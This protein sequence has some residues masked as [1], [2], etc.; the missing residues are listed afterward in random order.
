MI[1][2]SCYLR[3]RELTG[4]LASQLVAPQP[5]G[6]KHFMFWA[7]VLHPSELLQRSKT[8]RWDESL[9][10]DSPWMTWMS[11]ILQLFKKLRGSEQ[12]LWP[13]EHREL[14]TEFMLVANMLGLQKM[15]MCLYKLRHG[16]A[17]EDWLRQLRP[18]AAIRERGRWG[19][20]SSLMRYQKAS[21]AQQ[22][23]SKI[24]PAVIEFAQLVQSD[25]PKWFRNPQLL[26]APLA[27]CLQK[28][29]KRK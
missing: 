10:L 18:L 9:L 5:H 27:M 12:S 25:L 19:S 23:L 21:R 4:L 17:S 14:V 22:E 8:G 28:L 11:E 29:R 13:F 20:D 15:D 7:I 26:Q 16:G 3:P 24:P 1:G 6:G 2:F